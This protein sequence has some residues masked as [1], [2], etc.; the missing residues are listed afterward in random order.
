MEK[1]NNIKSSFKPVR[2]NFYAA[3]HMFDMPFTTSETQVTEE[4]WVIGRLY[5]QK[6]SKCSKSI[7]LLLF[8]RA[9]SYHP[10]VCSVSS[11]TPRDDTAFN[12]TQKNTFVGVSL[13]AK[14]L[15]PIF[16]CKNQGVKH[17]FCAHRLLTRRKLVYFYFLI[18]FFSRGVGCVFLVSFCLPWH[19]SPGPIIQLHFQDRGKTPKR[20]GLQRHEE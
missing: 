17:S 5:R 18:E 15:I 13:I 14:S 6:M 1:W 8:L 3:I 19:R 11:E 16:R 12:G 4:N 7:C 2:M 20:W 10:G 9:W